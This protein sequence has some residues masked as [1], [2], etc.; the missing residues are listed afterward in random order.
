MRLPARDTESLLVVAENVNPGWRARLDGQEL[1]AVTVDGW[2]Q[3]WL[4][5][6]GADTVVELDMAPAPLYRGALGAGALGGL[7]ALLI[8]LRRGQPRPGPLPA[9]RPGRV[10]GALGGLLGLVLLAGTAGAVAWVVAVAGV[11]VVRRRGRVFDGTAGAVLPAALAGVVVALRPWASD[12]YA[13]AATPV[14]A[15]LLLSL[16]FVVAPR[17]PGRAAASP[18]PPGSAS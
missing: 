2:Q 1:R 12:G 13:G 17:G 6:A 14:T 3:A 4:V 11:A 18:A 16:A 9:A 10:L 15:A 5:P 7:V 8:A